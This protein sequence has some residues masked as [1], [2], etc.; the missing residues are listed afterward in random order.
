MNSHSSDGCASH[1]VS[2]MTSG[3]HGQNSNPVV[4]EQPPASHR[5]AVSVTVGTRVWPQLHA[6]LSSSTVVHAGS[7]THRDWPA[8]AGGDVHPAG[9]T[10]VVTEG[11]T[12]AGHTGM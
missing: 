3:P 7:S 4:V 2:L 9:R 5:Q 6:T 10:V 1:A 8:G 12:P 11:Q